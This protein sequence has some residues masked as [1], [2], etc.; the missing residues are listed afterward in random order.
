MHFRRLAI[1][2]LVSNIPSF[3]A[4]AENPPP[5]LSI[6]A[7]VKQTLA[8]NPEVKFYQAEIVAAKGART[9][10]GRLPNP[11]LNL[12]L[13]RKSIRSSDA[14][15]SGVAW[16][17]SLAQPIEWPGRLGL[18][19]AIA[20][21]DIALAEL[22]LERFKIALAGKV[23]SL[24][25]GLAL[26]QERAAAA[27]EVEDR[28]TALRDV[29]VQRD[30][31]GVTPL[32]ETKV[33]EATAVVVQKQAADAAIEMQKLSWN[34]INCAAKARQLRLLFAEPTSHFPTTDRPTSCSRR[35]LRTTT[36]SGSGFANWS[37]KV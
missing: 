11:E 21:R 31:A 25:Y 27:A 28:L 8:E 15:A 24:A 29:I 3:Q 7:L 6:D 36:K 20:N 34:S 33:I 17:A 9:I 23:R 32:L 13:G 30:P 14:S 22:G 37:S 1:T 5:P 16:A 35:L 4:W 18:R 19:K 2:L 26:Q 10:A 12:D